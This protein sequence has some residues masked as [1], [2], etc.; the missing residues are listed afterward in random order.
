LAQSS[1]A[2]VAARPGPD[3]TK[4]AWREWARVLRTTLDFTTLSHEVCEGLAR[5]PPLRHAAT[6]LV[7]LPMEDEID[8]TELMRSG[9]PM[10]W[11]ATRTPDQGPLTIHELGGPVETHRFGFSQ[12]LA[13]ASPVAPHEID[14]AL[15]PGMV[16]DLY[17]SRLG[18]GFG[19]FDH[20][21]AELRPGIVRVGVTPSALVADRLPREP[22]DVPVQWLAAEEGVVGVVY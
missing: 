10:R 14:I 6:V 21:M 3:A 8:L 2:D 11:V 5:F 20:L 1:V 13:S 15:V 17:G 16:F 12:P 7:Y 19:Y 18:H 22:H 9:L 4:E